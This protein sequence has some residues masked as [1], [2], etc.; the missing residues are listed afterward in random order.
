MT[1]AHDFLFKKIRAFMESFD[2]SSLTTPEAVEKKF[3][4]CC[5][6]TNQLKSFNRLLKKKIATLEKKSYL[7]D[8]EVI[9]K[10]LRLLRYVNIRLEDTIAKADELCSQI[11]KIL[12]S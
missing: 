10:N 12:H 11:E 8:N 2:P 3:A 4:E 6:L 9:E 1:M 7:N 5:E